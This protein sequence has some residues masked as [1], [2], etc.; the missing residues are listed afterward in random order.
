MPLFWKYRIKNSSKWKTRFLEIHRIS[1]K[2]NPENIKKAMFRRKNACIREVH[3]Y[4]IV[5]LYYIAH[6]KV[7]KS[8]NT[9]S[10]LMFFNGF[11]TKK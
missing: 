6:E 8:S 9:T 10:K 4:K 3:F 11:W 7:R 2:N 5:F 1:K